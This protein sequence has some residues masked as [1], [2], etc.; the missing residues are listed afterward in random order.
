MVRSPSWVNA[1]PVEHEAAAHGWWR[2]ADGYWYPPDARPGELWQGEVRGPHGEHPPGPGWW[3]ASNYQWY[4]PDAR[5]GEVWGTP[6]AGVSRESRA[7]ATAQWDGRSAN[8]N[9]AAMLAA[10]GLVLIILGIVL[11]SALERLSPGAGA[12]MRLAAWLP[13]GV[14]SSLTLLGAMRY[15][16]PAK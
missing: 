16:E 2:A 1:D 5:P 8:R 14:G 9:D 10:G 6:V 15:L 7:G 4:P 13:V 12:W 3:L 11:L